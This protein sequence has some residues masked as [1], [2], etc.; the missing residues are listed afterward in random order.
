MKIVVLNGS[1][2]LELSITLQSIKYL[3]KK[4]LQDDFKIIHLIKSVRSGEEQ[5]INDMDIIK[6]ADIIIWSFPLYHLLVP[7]HMKV[8]IE[9]IFSLDLISNFKDKHTAVFTTSIHYCDNIAHDYMEG[10]CNDLNMKYM[11]FLSHDMKDFLKE[12]YRDELDV[13]YRSLKNDYKTKT[14]YADRS[15]MLTKSD[16]KYT[17]KELNKKSAGQ[18]SLVIVT[19]SAANSG[20]EEMIKTIVSFVENA[21]V[22]DI[23]QPFNY[24]IGCCNCAPKNICAFHDKDN[25]RSTLD[26]ILEYDIILFAGDIVDRYLSSNFKKFFDR[27]FCYTHIPIFAKKQ[28]G[29]IVSGDYYN[30]KALKEIFEIYGNGGNFLG[31]INDRS[32]D[33]EMIA[34]EIT[35]MVLKGIE[36][37]NSGYIK[38]KTCRSIAPQMIFEKEISNS[39]G[40]L[41]IMDYKYYKENNMLRPIKPHLKL[42]NSL[43]RRLLGSDKVLEKVYKKMYSGM[44][45]K[46]KKVL[47]SIK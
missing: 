42:R 5:I 10:I 39:L 45:S 36:Y 12:E 8:Y 41:F 13:F 33:D 47:D 18:A 7:S 22:V 26:E 31:V 11:G 3:E 6:E 40:V 9:K 37:A 25:Y 27:S 32:K 35:D 20:V 23:N 1:P 16:Y 2:K 14:H 19:D 46:H 15:T 17:H 28:L 24:C 38:T 43:I 30:L 34:D 4:N 44:I 29:Y 21:K